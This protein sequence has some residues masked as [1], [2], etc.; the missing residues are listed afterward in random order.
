MIVAAHA[1]FTNSYSAT[2]CIAVCYHTSHCSI[3]NA[4]ISKR[5][6]LSEQMFQTCCGLNFFGNCS[7]QHYDSNLT[8]TVPCLQ[9]K[10]D[11]RNK[12]THVS[13]DQVGCPQC[14]VVSQISNLKVCTKSTFVRVKIMTSHVPWGLKPLWDHF[15]LKPTWSMGRLPPKQSGLT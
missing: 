7:Y 14:S 13:S 5:P 1:N 2:T 10:S 15:L 12:T 3:W 11:V 8:W 6:L 4:V 9:I